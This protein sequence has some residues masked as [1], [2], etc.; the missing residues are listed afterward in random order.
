MIK[1][2]M[3]HGS[4]PRWPGPARI[5]HGTPTVPQAVAVAVWEEACAW[6]GEELPRA[7]L[8]RL[9]ERAEAVYA[10]NARVRRRLRGPGNGGRDWL[11]TF[12]RHWLAALLRQHRPDLHS[13]LPDTFNV[14]HPLASKQ[15]SP[16]RQTPP[17][18]YDDQLLETMNPNQNNLTHFKY[19]TLR[20]RW[21]TGLKMPF[22]LMPWSELTL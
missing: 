8:V 12:T 15:T 2:T 7:W 4:W 20:Q 10:S 18:V 11:W 16:K 14:G 1:D 17:N 6:L 19:Q 5:E 21:E 22:P 3:I 13:R 9:A